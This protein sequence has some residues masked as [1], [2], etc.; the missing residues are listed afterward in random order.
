VSH[1]ELEG[2]QL[3]Y[4]RI[5]ERG[6]DAELLALDGV[7]FDVASGEFVAVVGPSG[8]GKSSLLL[9]VNGLLK[10]TAGQV[11]LDGEVIRAPSADRALV[12]QE[13]ALLPWRTVQANVELP[14]ELRRAPAPTR[15]EIASRHLRRVG[16]EAYSRFFPHE[17]SGGMRQRVGLARALAVD[18][19]V[20]L[21]DEPF[22]ALDAQMRQLMG[23][24]LLRL[25]EAEKKTIL[26]VTH[27]LDEAIYLA[28]R[29]VVMSARP[30]RVLDLVPIA[31]PRP[32]VLA[33][34]SSAEFGVYRQRI[35][36][37]L[38]REVLAALA[39]ESGTDPDGRG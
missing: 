21:M 36:Q 27:D 2:V 5:T 18:P 6:D 13:S 19:R 39:R 3:Y 31:L 16:L 8:C 25:W 35:W 9:L 24:E 22:A 7:S 29:V 4:R 28:D 26:F 37:S 34:R 20:L 15:R 14:L 30:G 1:L 12:F 23:A 10:P 33:I 38:E 32:R 11:R 17:V